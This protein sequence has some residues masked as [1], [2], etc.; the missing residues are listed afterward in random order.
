MTDHTTAP[1]AAQ[2]YFR[3]RG[4]LPKT[5]WLSAQRTAPAPNGTFAWPDASPLSTNITTTPYTH[6]A[7][8]YPFIVKSRGYDCVCAAEEL[9]YDVYLGT[10]T[11]DDYVSSLNYL[12]NDANKHGW[13]LATCGLKYYSICQLP[14]TAFACLPPPNPPHPPPSPPSPPSPPMPPSCKCL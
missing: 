10:D 13:N 7:W 3:L 4:A 1:P 9:A 2:R 12:V 6:W 5:Y 8:Y 11:R 14:A